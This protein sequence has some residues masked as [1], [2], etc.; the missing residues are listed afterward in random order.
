MIWHEKPQP[1]WTQPSQRWPEW[2]KAL[3]S[4][5]ALQNCMFLV[6]FK[7]ESSH[8]GKPSI[9]QSWAELWETSNTSK[10]LWAGGG[11]GTILM[12][13]RLKGGM[14]PGW[15]EALPCSA[16][17]VS[18]L[19]S[20]GSWWLRLGKEHRGFAAEIVFTKSGLEVGFCTDLTHARGKILMFQ[21]LS[22][23]IGL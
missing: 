6:K 21:N 7:H 23:P 13:A 16:G 12:C 14:C 20:P 22:C 3:I 10:T 5:R 15:L 1:W 4:Q 11:I 19:P 8:K 9:S 17:A 18:A 2:L